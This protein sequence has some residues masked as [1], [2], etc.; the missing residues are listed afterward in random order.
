MIRKNTKSEPRALATNEFESVSDINNVEEVS[1]SVDNLDEHES[2]HESE[3]SVSTEESIKSHIPSDDGDE[4]EQ[5]NSFKDNKQMTK[6]NSNS[7]D[8]IVVKSGGHQKNTPLKANTNTNNNNKTKQK[9]KLTNSD[10][11]I[12]TDQPNRK[13]DSDLQKIE[14]SLSGLSTLKRV[15]NVKVITDPEGNNST[16]KAKFSL[17]PLILRVEKSM[18]R[19]GVKNVKSATAHTNAMMGRIKFSVVNDCASL[20]SIKVQ[21]PKQVHEKSS[22]S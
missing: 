17:G 9:N 5:A 4:K 7:H 19:G 18:K 3:A 8:A 6:T 13:T 21:Q 22:E 10:N 14:G 20:V 16:I 2:D 15:G 1:M 12:K 11:A